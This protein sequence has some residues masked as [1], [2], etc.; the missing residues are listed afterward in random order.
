MTRRTITE[1]KPGGT[2]LEQAVENALD[3][4]V[5]WTNDSGF[6]HGGYRPAI[7]DGRPMP[8]MRQAGKHR[9]AVFN[10][11]EITC[12]DCLATKHTWLCYP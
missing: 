6:S 2:S 11:Y 7:C 9:V 5:C 12:Q 1:P 4:R 8:D 3:I 10:K